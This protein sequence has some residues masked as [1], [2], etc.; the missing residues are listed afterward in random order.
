MARD[1]AVGCGRWLWLRVGD[2]SDADEGE[3]ESLDVAVW[4][5]SLSSSLQPAATAGAKMQD[6]RA[7]MSSLADKRSTGGSRAGGSRAGVQTGGIV[8]QRGQQKQDV[9]MRAE[10]DDCGLA[11]VRA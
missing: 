5:L 4:L 10:V 6:C 8:G 3:V 7:G 9:E 11:G 1:V 2:R